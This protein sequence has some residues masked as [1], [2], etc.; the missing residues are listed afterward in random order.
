MVIGMF[1]AGNVRITQSGGAIVAGI[2]VVRALGTAQRRRVVVNAHSERNGKRTTVWELNASHVRANRGNVRQ[3][4]GRQKGGRWWGNAAQAY[5]E[6]LR[7][8]VGAQR[9]ARGQQNV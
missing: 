7:A 8:R 3:N 2:V 4:S 9:N 1:T 6:T 5:G